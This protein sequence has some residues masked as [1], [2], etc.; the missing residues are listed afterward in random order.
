MDEE[1]QEEVTEVDILSVSALRCHSKIGC[2]Q[3]S[4]V[5]ATQVQ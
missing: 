3:H 2:W 1:A 5:Q 4:D